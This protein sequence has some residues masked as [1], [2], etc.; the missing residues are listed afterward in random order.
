[1]ANQGIATFYLKVK[2]KRNILKK[3]IIP[4]KIF[5]KIHIMLAAN[6]TVMKVSRFMCDISEMK[7]IS[8]FNDH[9]ESL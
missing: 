8:S 7:E 1:M 9:D 5:Q 4:C 2:G 6:P 3:L